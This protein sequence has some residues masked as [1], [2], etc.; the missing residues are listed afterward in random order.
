METDIIIIGGG[1]VGCAIAYYL[2]KAG[3]SVTVVERGEIGAQASGAAAGLLAPLGPLSGPGPLADFLLA[4]CTLLLS[5][6]ETLAAETG[7][8]TGYRQTGALRTVLHPKRV[9]RLKKRWESW[10][11]LGLPMHWLSGDEAR[12]LEPQLSPDVC[13]AVYA[14]TEG[15]IQ[16]RPFVQSLVQAARQQGA[17]IRTHTEA[18]AIE[19][20]GARV[21]GVRTVQGEV[22]SCQALVVAAGA[23][24][25]HCASWL[26]P[27]QSRELPI[28]PLRGQ[29]LALQQP[30]PA[31]QRII[32]GEA[33][34]LVPG[35]ETIIV[36]ATREEA[37]FDLAVTEEGTT[38]LQTTAQRLIPVL[39]HSEM[40]TAWAGLRPKTPDNQP[41]LGPLPGWENV[42]MAAGHNSI[43]IMTGALTGQTIAD[44]LIT[45][46]LAPIIRPFS[47]ERFSS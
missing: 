20:S 28:R 12:Q 5:L 33:A 41:L 47:P 13:A 21:T 24:A 25:A 36:G 39:T 6:V 30:V 11:P 9:A 44:F 7:L 45:G 14:P 46:Q 2:S 34:Y 37:G 26:L 42:V 4:G 23:W 15:Q 29:L 40:M 1:V 3:V 18:V 22:L 19:R 31:L 10:K 27:E 8:H 32:F 43:G 38:W 35:N 17:I 16:A